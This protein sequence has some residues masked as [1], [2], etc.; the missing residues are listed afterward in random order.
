MDAAATCEE[1]ANVVADMATAATALKCDARASTPNDAPIANAAGSSG[2]MTRRPLR[3]PLAKHA[4]LLAIAA[5][6]H[7][8]P[9]PRPVARIVDERPAARVGSAGLEALPRPIGHRLGCGGEHAAE[10]A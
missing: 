2:A 8:A 4:R 7:R 3:M 5:D 9:L 10:C 6:A 1:P